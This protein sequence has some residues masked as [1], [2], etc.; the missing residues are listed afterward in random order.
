MASC[1]F[2]VF[3]RWEETAY[4]RYSNAFSLNGG[5]LNP[6]LQFLTQWGTYQVPHL[7]EQRREKAWARILRRFEFLL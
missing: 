7:S 1:P 4:S 6:A 5:V 2:C 3:G